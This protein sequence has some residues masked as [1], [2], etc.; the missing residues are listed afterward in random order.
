MILLCILISFLIMLSYNIVS[1]NINK[2]NMYMLILA[3]SCL[4]VSMINVME[5]N[6]EKFEEQQT[7]DTIQTIQT[8][9]TTTTSSD[10]EKDHIFSVPDYVEELYLHEPSHRL[11]DKLIFYI[12]TFNK[13]FIDVNNKNLSNLI[14]NHNTSKL[15]MVIPT[16]NNLQFNVSQK[17]GLLIDQSITYVIN[18]P[19]QINFNHRNFTIFFYMK[20]SDRQLTDKK[21][22]LIHIPTIDN[23][24]EYNNN[25]LLS[26]DLSYETTDNLNPFF[27]ISIFGNK[28]KSDKFSNSELLKNNLFFND[29]KYHLIT[30]VRY[31]NNDIQ[32]YVDNNVQNPL[33]NE[34]LVKLP[35][36]D[37]KITNENV[38]KINNIESG[39]SP[40]NVYLNCFGIYNRSLTKDDIIT[41]EKYIEDVK[42]NFEPN[43][44]KINDERQSYLDL[45]KK[46]TECPFHKKTICDEG[47][48]KYVKDWSKVNEIL[49]DDKC[50]KQVVEYCDNLDSFDNDRLCGS[51]NTNA[52]HRMALNLDY[53][54]KFT[55]QERTK[56]DKKLT[57]EIEKLGLKDIYLDKSIRTGG[58]NDDQMKDL[59]ENLLKTKDVTALNRLYDADAE[60]DSTKNNNTNHI[61]YSSLEKDDMSYNMLTYDEFYNSLKK[62]E[63][64]TNTD[65]I[66]KLNEDLITIN[67][68]DIVKEDAYKKTIDEY[69]KE[70]IRKNVE[71]STTG[72]LNNIF[73]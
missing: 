3:Y 70:N 47:H 67:N 21:T 17:D 5:Y 63:E 61:D 64:T 55:N 1:S 10:E 8:T 18:T 51:M 23:L 73:R 49:Y 46:S 7:S 4:F 39:Y 50:F 53:E 28:Y 56:E 38:I 62:N 42:V 60:E 68:D 37:I 24:Y 16:M 25:T 57:K 52:V 72:I 22:Q 6:V 40:L 69:E 65:D 19:Y 35:R 43:Y 48:C 33:I 71:S 14:Q 66:L 20:I 11:K 34:K 27:E 44:I 30:F 41:L 32:I 26:I 2:Y 59:I 31:E 9:P 13:R 12:S 15:K 29:E 54:N 58:I 45:Y 36:D